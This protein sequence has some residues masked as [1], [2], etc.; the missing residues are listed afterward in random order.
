M[1]IVYSAGSRA[2]SLPVRPVS[3]QE[4]VTVQ[5]YR[6]IPLRSLEACDTKCEQGLERLIYMQALI[7]EDWE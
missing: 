3:G 5:R 1:D 4:K 6:L 7:D 2:E